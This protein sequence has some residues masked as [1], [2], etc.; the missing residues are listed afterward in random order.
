MRKRNFFALLLL[1]VTG[2]RGQVQLPAVQQYAPNQESLSAL[3]EIAC[4]GCSVYVPSY[5]MG[6]SYQSY[7]SYSFQPGYQYT[8]TINGFATA[9]GNLP[10]PATAPIYFGASLGPA[11]TSTALSTCAPFPNYTYLTDYD[12]GETYNNSAGFS[13]DET[14]VFNNP[15]LSNVVTIASFPNSSTPSS[16]SLPPFTVSA[17]TTGLNI[18]SY[19]AQGI[20]PALVNQSGTGAF[21]YQDYNG[22]ATPT[23]TTF[24]INSITITQV[25]TQ[26]LLNGVP[27]LTLSEANPS[28]SGTITGTPGKLVKVSVAVTSQRDNTGIG[29]SLTLTTAGIDFTTGSNEVFASNVVNG[30]I[31]LTG[32]ASASF[33]MPASGS[34]SFSAEA[35]AG[36]TLAFAQISVSN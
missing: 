20:A 27:E 4:G 30:V 6:N 21:F 28:V 18:E 7:P 14:V 32:S 23:N 5:Y 36:S 34:V 16:V 12:T 35:S 13:F 17:T 24:T 15:F 26:P 33:T 9:T 11:A 1:V 22:P 19:P 10:T 2:T 8:V 25:Q 3:E 31:K 29:A